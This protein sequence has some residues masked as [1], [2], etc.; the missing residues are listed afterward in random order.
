MEVVDTVEIHV[1]SV[2]GEGGLPHAKVQVGRV[3]PL[4][5]D[6]IHML[7]RVQDGVQF[8]DVPI[9]HILE[10]TTEK[11]NYCCWISSSSSAL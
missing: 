8:A 2:P 9:S 3:H 6:A 7:H 4:D 10:R 1:F 5:G 11:C